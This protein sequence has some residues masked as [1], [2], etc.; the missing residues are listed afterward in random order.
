MLLVNNSPRCRLRSRC[1]SHLGQSAGIQP[2][3]WLE[4]TRERPR[5]LC[6]TEPLSSSPRF[7]VNTRDLKL[8]LSL[9][10]CYFLLSS[11]P[12]SFS[13][14]V[15]KILQRQGEVKNIDSIPTPTCWKG[16]KSRTEVFRG[17]KHGGDDIWAA[18]LKS[19]LKGETKN[20]VKRHKETL[21][22]VIL[23]EERRG[24]F[25]LSGRLFKQKRWRCFK[26]RRIRREMEISF[27]TK[28]SE[29]NSERS[30]SCRT[31]AGG[32]SWLLICSNIIVKTEIYYDGGV[33][34]EASRRHGDTNTRP[35]L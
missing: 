29:N 30:S 3:L 25:P 28:K 10:L 1:P 9:F 21:S 5:P 17:A 18:G 34:E 16:N 26:S 19:E 4:E 14:S 31:A 12:S 7:W 13:P 20:V 23:G 35:L 22:D 11:S 24:D 27:S 32:G 15:C 2:A 33:N 6:K 8:N